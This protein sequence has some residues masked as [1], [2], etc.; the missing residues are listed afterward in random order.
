V[1]QEFWICQSRVNSNFYLFTG[2]LDKEKK[3]QNVGFR[4]E[5]C[6]QYLFPY[7]ALIPTY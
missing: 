6:A 5:S 7:S 1:Y 3:I 4:A 2:V